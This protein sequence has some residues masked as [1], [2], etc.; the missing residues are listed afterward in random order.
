VIQ[1]TTSGNG[2]EPLGEPSASASGPAKPGN[3]P[4]PSAVEP[5]PPERLKLDP[6][7]G[8]KSFHASR[9]FADMQARARK[10]RRGRKVAI[11]LTALVIG[12]GIFAMT[13][14]LLSWFVH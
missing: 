3:F 11:V 6:Y 14:H 8:P 2:S 4:A 5:P 9:A 13:G 7:Y 10:R 1:R 12:G